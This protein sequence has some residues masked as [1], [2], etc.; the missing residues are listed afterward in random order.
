LVGELG[1]LF[2]RLALT[3]VFV[4]HDHDEAFAVADRLAVMVDGRLVRIGPPE[5]VWRSPGDETVAR[6]LGH[7]NL[8]EVGPDGSL[9]WGGRLDPQGWAG[10][11]VV[12]PEDAVEVTGADD[13]RTGFRARVLG[14]RF[15]GG[16]RRVR[17]GSPGPGGWELTAVTVTAPPVG[18]AVGVRVDATRLVAVTRRGDPQ[19]SS[20]R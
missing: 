9:P 20:T 12:V 17:L 15:A 6:F 7:R 16:R 18:A 11:L 3:V 2:A 1:D 19:A 4:T 10:R 8:V 5:E 14:V 13:P